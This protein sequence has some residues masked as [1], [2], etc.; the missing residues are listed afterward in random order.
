MNWTL[1]HYSAYYNSVEVGEILISKG[2]NI[3]AKDSVFHIII[4]LFFI[5]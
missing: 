5:N 3:D 1:L 4:R 2:A